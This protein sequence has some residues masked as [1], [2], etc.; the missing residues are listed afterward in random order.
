MLTKPQII[1]SLIDRLPNSINQK[2]ILSDDKRDFEDKVNLDQ[3]FYISGKNGVGKTH[4]ITLFLRDY[5]CSIFPNGF[6][7]ANYKLVPIFVKMNMFERYVEE[8]NGFEEDSKYG[9]KLAL[10]EMKYAKLLI[11][12]DFWVSEGTDRFKSLC[13]RELFE[14][15]DY[16]YENSL[17]TILTTNLNLQKVGEIDSEY[18]RITSRL[19]GLCSEL[20]LPNKIDFRNQNTEI[21]PKVKLEL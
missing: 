5:L 9:A 16:R 14:I 19:F 11:L 15:L 10:E 7:L 17:Q 13:K 12:D 18:L 8:R 6:E 21:T 1:S 2:V 3:S 20:D 4:Y